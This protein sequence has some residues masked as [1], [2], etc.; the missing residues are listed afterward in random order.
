VAHAH[1][2]EED[3]ELPVVGGV[4]E[5]EPAV[6]VEQV[7]LGVGPVAELSEQRLDLLALAAEADEV[8]VLALACQRR[9]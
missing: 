8:D 2:V 4:P 7:E 3:I 5:V 9:P 6:A 1:A